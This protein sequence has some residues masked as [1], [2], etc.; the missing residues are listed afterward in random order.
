[1][2]I[3]AYIDYF[4][5]LRELPRDQQFDLLVKA[6]DAA[7]SELMLKSFER[8][9]ITLRLVCLLFF[10]SLSYLI[11]PNSTIAIVTSTVL[12][13]VISRIVIKEKTE[14]LLQREIK[15]LLNS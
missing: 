12:A 6:K 11:W 1:M 15:K 4:P 8:M 9:S 13:L 7:E 3:K 14:S 10:I 5:Q 2:N